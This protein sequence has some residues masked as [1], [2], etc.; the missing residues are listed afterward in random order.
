MTSY[1][2][3]LVDDLHLKGRFLPR[4]KVAQ[5]KSQRL[6]FLFIGALSHGGY[7]SSRNCI[8]VHFLRPL[9]LHDLGGCVLFKFFRG[10]GGLT[11]WACN[12]WAV[13]VGEAVFMLW[14]S[15]VGRWTRL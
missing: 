4:S 11:P 13:F 7:I 12:T 14:L 6:L 2:L 3:Q 9:L 15:S 8:F 5:L 10:E 1:N